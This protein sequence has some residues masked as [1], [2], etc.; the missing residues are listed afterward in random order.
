[1]LNMMLM[2]ALCYVLAVSLERFLMVN[3]QKCLMLMQHTASFDLKYVT[4]ISYLRYSVG[5]YKELVTLLRF[6]WAAL[7][8]YCSLLDLFKGDAS[9]KMRE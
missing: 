9:V 6:E 8:R 4:N 1:M 7:S 3:L 5:H 2:L